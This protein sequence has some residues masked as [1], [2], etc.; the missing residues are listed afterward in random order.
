[1]VIA[2][3]VFGEEKWERVAALAEQA[4]IT[5]NVDNA[6]ALRGLSAAA[7]RHEVTIAVQIEI[8]TGFHRCGLRMDDHAAIEAL[9]REA[10]AQPGIDF[11]GVTTHRGVFFDGA[12][13]MTVE[14]AGRQEGELLVSVA[15]RLRSTGITVHEVTAG[16]TITGRAVATVPG[17]TEVRA[18]TYVF[19]DLMQLRLGSAA[20]DDLAL[21]VL[22]TVVS[23]QSPD[24]VTIDAGS[25][26]L[27]GDRGVVGGGGDAP[28][29]IARSADG[30]A[31]VE[32]ITEEHGMVRVGTRPVALGDRLRFV[33]T[34]ACTCV[35]LS[36]EIVGIR[37]GSV[38][39][40]WPVLA[41]GKRT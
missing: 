27:S 28:A 19:N 41:R 9:A 38:E 29:E 11:E 10:I 36:D 35:N 22:S 15:E 20:V 3:P 39:C 24:R 17:I 37:A 40:V 8:D 33:P 25:K 1:V 18:G 4:K 21:T 31:F 16:G 30:D 13:A 23:A 12:E 34:H 6:V 26:T 32:Q 7:T 2:Y 5:V 14:E